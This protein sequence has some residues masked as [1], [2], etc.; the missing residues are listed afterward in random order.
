MCVCVTSQDKIQEGSKNCRYFRRAEYQSK[1]NT[2]YCGLFVS[3]VSQSAIEKKNCWYF[4]DLQQEFNTEPD[5]HRNVSGS[6]LM[7]ATNFQKA[8]LEFFYRLT[9]LKSTAVKK[10]KK[11][12]FHQKTALM[13]AQG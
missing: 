9:L 8:A 4:G 12:Q 10:K 13:L 3:A 2:D 6:F 1:T 11:K 5:H 7:H